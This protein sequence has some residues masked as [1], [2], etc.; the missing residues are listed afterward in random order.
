MLPNGVICY[1]ENIL[2]ILQLYYSY[3]G[4]LQ[5]DIWYLTQGTNADLTSHN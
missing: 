2:P 4:Y 5:R 3:T 1:L